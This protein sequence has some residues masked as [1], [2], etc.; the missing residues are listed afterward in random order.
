M[1]GHNVNTAT[2]I[3]SMN[4]FNGDARLYKVAPP[5][6]ID[7]LFD[8]DDKTTD[9]IIVSAVYVLGVPETYIFASN[10]D[11]EISNW[12]ELSGSF[13]GDIDHNEALNRAGYEVQE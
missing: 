3:K 2:F 4:G 5:M 10:S 9:H 13:K 1:K 6:S 12:G 11:G 7:S 8:E